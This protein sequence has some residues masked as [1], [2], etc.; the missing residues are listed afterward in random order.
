MDFDDR[1]A[2]E[3]LART[4]SF[5]EPLGDF[6]LDWYEDFLREIV[7]RD[8]RVVTFKELFEDSDDWD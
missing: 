5:S 8:I 7:R 2:L 1:K 3:E 4:R 6:P